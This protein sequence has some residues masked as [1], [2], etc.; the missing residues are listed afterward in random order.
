MKTI[1]ILCLGILMAKTGFGQSKDADN[2]FLV[3]QKSSSPKYFIMGNSAYSD[4]Y[5]ADK[6]TLN[7]KEYHSVIRT[8]SWGDA[9][10]A[11]YREDELNYYHFDQKNNMES[12]VLPKKVTI[13]Q[14]WF[15]ADKS[16]SYKIID[17]DDKLETPE[18]THTGLIVIECVQLTGRDKAKSKVY[19]MYYAKGIGMVGS[20][21]DGILTSY[22]TEAK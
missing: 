10:T 13:G 4:N 8:Y 11:Y 12:I 18:K 21:N 3:Q 14:I 9:D 22:L 5:L 19:H 7:N 6:K 17:I 20:V 2:Y 1:T 15:E 16:W